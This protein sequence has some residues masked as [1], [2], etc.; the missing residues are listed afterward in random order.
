M[1]NALR[2]FRKSGW[3]DILAVLLWAAAA[4]SLLALIGFATAPR[5]AAGAAP[6]PRQT[7]GF[8]AQNR[9][10][11]LGAALAAL[12]AALLILL[13]FAWLDV[14]AK[15]SPARARRMGRAGLAL[16]YLF[17]TALT[18]LMVFPIYWMVISSLKTADELLL[19]VPTLWPLSF[20]WGNY[21]EVLRRAPFGLYFVNTMVSTFLIMAGQLSIG[22]LA[23]FAC[24]KGEFR[25]KNGL[26]IM[27]LGALMIPIQITFVPIYVMVANLGWINTF[28]GLVVPNLVSAYFIFMLRQTFMSVD[29]SYID[30]G[31]ID[32]MGRIGTIVHVLCP[33]CRPTLITV[34]IITFINGWNSYFWPKMVTTKDAR[35]T[36]AVGINHL[37]RTFAGV[38]TA[39]YNEIMAGAVLAIL[40]IVALFLLLQ[41]HIMTGVSKAAMK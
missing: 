31:K 32:G 24:S 3:H 19:P 7:G 1:R 39:N 29:D 18:A 6:D 33:M 25:W 15:R 10:L 28:Q 38:E 8:L 26:F 4:L 11:F 9:S 12:A 40:P 14:W 34:T 5:P 35:R 30:A 22:I 36:L 20:Q 21:P 16:Q 13:V 2:E 23:A 41:K 37:R 27:V 17:S